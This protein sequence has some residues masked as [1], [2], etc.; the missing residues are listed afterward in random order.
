MAG[1]SPVPLGT[2]V[3][4][5]T[6]AATPNSVT[7]PARP[8]TVRIYNSGDATVYIEVG[9]TATVP[10]VGTPGSMPLASGAGSIPLLFEKGLNTT[11]SAVAPAGGTFPRNIFI[12]L[13]AGDTVG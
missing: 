12:S 3:L 7:L 13:G 2:Y 10:S 11:I 6:A 5:L 1:F 4:Q 8:G 9:A